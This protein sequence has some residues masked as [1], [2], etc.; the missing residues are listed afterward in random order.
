MRAYITEP[1]QDVSEEATAVA[2]P[3]TTDAKTD[4][5]VVDRTDMGAQ[6]QTRGWR[7]ENFP[8]QPALTKGAPPELGYQ[9]GISQGDV[10]VGS[11]KDDTSIGMQ[12]RAGGLAEEGGPEQAQKKMPHHMITELKQVFLKASRIFGLE[13]R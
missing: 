7:K 4:V 8:E 13:T 6:E 5:A 3:A 11:G 1:D 2:A 9:K 10:D 12:K